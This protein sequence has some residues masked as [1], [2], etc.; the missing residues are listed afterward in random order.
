MK[1]LFKQKMREWL[2][3][4]AL[5]RDNLETL[6]AVSA[7][8][9]Q[10]ATRALSFGRDGAWKKTLIDNLPLLQSPDCVDIACGTG[11]LCFLLARR[12]PQGR[13][14]AT[15]YNQQMLQLARAKNSYK[16]IEFVRAD[17][18][19]LA[20]IAPASVDLVT[21]GYALR[22]APDLNQALAEVRRIL[23]TGGTASFLEFS[24]PQSKVMQRIQYYI[25][26]GWGGLWGLLLHGNYEIYAYLAES[27][28]VF[29]THDA[30]MDKFAQQGFQEISSR[31]LF[32]GML[33]IITC[34]NA[35]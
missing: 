12:Y 9:Y 30:L 24:R 5:K 35:A 29:P 10:I 26:K 21:G 23:K 4:P 20:N 14:I 32:C 25:L 8:K 22:N 19:N 3:L 11:D 28:S 27:L 34:K 17:M 18:C 2:N 31:S 13:V 16:N 33:K 6:F 15:D 1:S 7:P